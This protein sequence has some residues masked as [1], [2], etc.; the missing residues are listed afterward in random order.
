MGAFRTL[1]NIYDDV[2]LQRFSIIDISQDCN[3]FELVGVSHYKGVSLSLTKVFECF[4]C[5][6]KFI[7][8]FENWEGRQSNLYIYFLVSAVVKSMTLWFLHKTLC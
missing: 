5:F 3:A 4:E 1:S 6:Q 7:A 8:F 2:F